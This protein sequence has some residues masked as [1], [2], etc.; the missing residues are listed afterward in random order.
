VYL[1]EHIFLQ[2]TIMKRMTPMAQISCRGRWYGWPW[3]TSGAAYAALP[4][5]VLLMS[6]A[7][8][9]RANPKSLTLML[10]W[11]S[12]RRFSHLRSLEI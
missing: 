4:Q 10:F 8:K 2:L 1:I 7:M 9:L 6:P 11:L 12:R 5:N 3:R